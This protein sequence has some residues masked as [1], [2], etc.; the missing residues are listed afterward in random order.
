MRVFHMIRRRGKRQRRTMKEEG[1]GH[2]RI[3]LMEGL[4][5]VGRER[6]SLRKD[7]LKG[8]LWSRKRKKCEYRPTLKIWLFIS[9]LQFIWGFVNLFY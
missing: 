4:R 8:M 2:F 3:P 9:Y 7:G 1:I 6:A 5:F